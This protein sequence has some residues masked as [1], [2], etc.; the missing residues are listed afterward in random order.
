MFEFVFVFGFTVFVSV[1]VFKCK[2]RKQL[3]SFSIEFDRFLLVG[4]KD[5]IGHAKLLHSDRQV[6]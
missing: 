3:S 1:F 2:N 4:K 6:C 5:K